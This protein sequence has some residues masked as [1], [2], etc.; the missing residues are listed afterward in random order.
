[1]EEGEENLKQVDE[2]EFNGERRRRCRR[3]TKS[4]G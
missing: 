1:M 2:V 3:K 4:G